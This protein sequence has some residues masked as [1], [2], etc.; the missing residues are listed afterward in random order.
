AYYHGSSSN[1]PCGATHRRCHGDSRSSP[2]PRRPPDRDCTASP[3]DRGYRVLAL[4][5]N[6]LFEELHQL[7]GAYDLSTWEE[8]RRSSPGASLSRPITPDYGHSGGG[9]P[10]RGQTPAEIG[11]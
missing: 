8:S 9:A 3:V 4:L 2:R 6:Q 11:R 5:R 7:T 10:A 1:D